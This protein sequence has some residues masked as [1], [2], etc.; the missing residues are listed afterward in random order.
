MPWDVHRGMNSGGDRQEHIP[1]C[2]AFL[3][4]SGSLESIMDLLMI[5]MIAVRSFQGQFGWN[6]F[7]V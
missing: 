6:L 3:N 1:G 4:G 7:Q 2:K 5:A